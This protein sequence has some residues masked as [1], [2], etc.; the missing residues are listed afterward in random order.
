[1]SYRFHNLLKGREPAGSQVFACTSLLGTFTSNTLVLRSWGFC[2]NYWLMNESQERCRMQ[3]D[4]HGPS[5]VPTGPPSFLLGLGPQH[6]L[7]S[8]DFLHSLCTPSPLPQTALSP[9][10]K[11]KSRNLARAEIAQVRVGWLCYLSQRSMV[12]HQ[13]QFLPA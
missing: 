11:A 7:F 12:L 5:R 3:R 4:H 9:F 1:M 2:P 8:A 10:F 6:E 13:P